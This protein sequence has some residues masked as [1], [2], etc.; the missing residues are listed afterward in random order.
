MTGSGQQLSLSPIGFQVVLALSQTPDGLRLTE[1]AHIIGSP[2]SSAQAALRVLM[3][4]G[5]V[6]KEGAETPR[7]VLS[8]AHPAGAALVGT[9]IVIGDPAR[10]IGVILRA[11]PAVA[12]AAVDAGGFLA[13]LEPNIQGASLETLEQHLKMIEDARPGSPVVERMPMPELERLVKVALDV[14]ARAREAL[15]IK[16]Q[17]P[18][19]ARM[20]PEERGD[21]AG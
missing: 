7:Y 15:T 2:V 14:R 4:N 5:V 18:V 6:R 20:S 17:A 1:I 21:R 3:S 19:A 9:A 12:W 13:G 10:S 11:N 16:G 8:P